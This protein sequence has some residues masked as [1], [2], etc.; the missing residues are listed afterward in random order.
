MSDTHFSQTVQQD[1]LGVLAGDNSIDENLELEDFCE[2]TED[3]DSINKIASKQAV[4][5]EKSA[6]ISE[7][8]SPEVPP[9]E[10]ITNANIP[11]TYGDLFDT[12]DQWINLTD[13]DGEKAEINYIPMAEEINC[14]DDLPHGD[15]EYAANMEEILA[16]IY[17]NIKKGVKNVPL[18]T[19]ITVDTLQ[20]TLS[21]YI[22]KMPHGIVDKQIAGIGATTLEINSKRNSIIVVPTKILAYSK[23]IKHKDKTL[24]VGGRI[25]RDRIATSDKE[26]TDYLTDKEIA[27]KK[28]LVVADSLSRLLEIIGKEQYKDYF[29][30]IDEVDMIQS[31][32]NYRSK[33][34]SLIDYYFQFPPKN[35][36]L[37]TA[38]MREFSNPR[39]QQEC[40]FKLTW[41]NP[42]KRDISLYYTDNVDAL[43]AECI[44]EIQNT[45]KIVIAFNSIRHCKNIIALLNAQYQTACAILCSESSKEEADGYYAELALDGKLPK[46]INFITSCYFA[47]VDIEDSY[48][49]I[50]VSNAQQNYQMLSLDKM[51]QIYGRCR[52]S[53]GIISDTIIANT[54][55]DKQENPNKNNQSALLKQ[56]EAI[57]QLQKA[58]SE[59]GKQDADLADLFRVVKTA[60]R[61]KAAIRLPREEPI[62]LTRENIY[63]ENVPAYMNIDYL[64]ERQKLCNTIYNSYKN[65]QFALEEQGHKVKFKYKLISP[66]A[67]QTELNTSLKK[68]VQD[69][70][71]KQLQKAIEEIREIA[72]QK[73][74]LSKDDLTKYLTQKSC[75][76][77]VQRLY[78]LRTLADTETLIDRLWEIRYS[79]KRAYNNLQNAAVFWALDDKH[80]FKRDLFRTFKI[81][82]KYKTSEI[83]ELLAPLVK[84]HFHKTI[85]QRA[86]VSLLKALFLI[87]RPKTYLI[88]GK[89]PMGFKKHGSLKIPRTEENLLKYFI[90]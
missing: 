88:K 83:H 48:H 74:E 33:L 65:L 25:S 76:E 21:S 50:T 56:A 46:R 49:L 61:E 63:K 11:N 77:Y 90:I 79:D 87:E 10:D 3:G 34:E 26:I 54:R 19:K 57:L 82:R 62:K 27:N 16:E 30:M 52:I 17:Q 37:V 66:T 70:I 31:E 68:E 73:E 69:I 85:K 38:T 84:Y 58:A 12:P 4:V 53:N 40:K 89:N 80:P 59:L 9:S 23:H 45:D 72:K 6:P 75:K 42:P 24:Y 44:H 71:D 81:G 1:V 60:I 86:A 5:P 51:T 35:R 29:L 43:T 55:D 7:E 36:C 78:K 67:E 22:Q 14:L 47:G 28:F 64:V 20:L 39:L 41:N 8:Q 2:A 18:E 15:M 13:G 32:S